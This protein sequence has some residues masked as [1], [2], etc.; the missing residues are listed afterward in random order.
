MVHKYKLNGM[1]IALDVSSGAIHILDDISYEMLDMFQETTRAQ[2]LEKYGEEAAGAYDELKELEEKGELY[3]ED[4][5]E[6]NITAQPETI[7]KAMCLHVSHDCNLRCKYCFAGTGN[8]GGARQ[9]MSKETAC[10]AMEYLA[11]HSGKRRNLEVDFFGGEPL[12]NMDAVKSAVS[13]AK[14]NEDNWGKKFNFTITTNGLL[15][16]DEN[17]KYIN[18]TMDNVVLSLDGRIETNDRMRKTVNNEGSYDK[19]LPKLKKMVEA[20]G[21]KKYYIR[22]TYTR[23]NLDFSEDVKQLAEEG[24]R[25]ISVEPVVAPKGSG[26][27]IREE[28]LPTLYKEYEKLAEYYVEMWQSEKWFNFFHFMIDLEHGPCAIKRLKGCGA[29]YEYIAVTP[30]GDIYPCHQFVGSGEFRMGNIEGGEIDK[31]ISEKFKQANIGSKPEC[32]KCWAKYY[33]S[34]GCHANAWNNAG[35]LEK[36]YEIGCELQRKRIECAIWAKIKTLTH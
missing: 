22:G 35:S 9:V 6:D 5:L 16:N 24:F 25:Q 36:P 33:C 13:H 18:E 28:D 3:S 10:R 34:G 2:I 26:Y 7:I 29:G 14:E 20:R 31:S 8:F 30:D 11:Q 4:E 19:I 21:D 1:N 32:K 12:M 27:E 17:I 15:L 23:E